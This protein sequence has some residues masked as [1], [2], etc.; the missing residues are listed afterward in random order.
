MAGERVPWERGAVKTRMTL[1]MVG[2][3]RR[4]FGRGKLTAL[5]RKALHWCGS[6]GWKGPLA[7]GQSKL[8]LAVGLYP[9]RCLH[10]ARQFL[11]LGISY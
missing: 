3:K 6:S 2:V 9:L 7:A 8:W 11:T 5:I 10:V 4:E 1:R